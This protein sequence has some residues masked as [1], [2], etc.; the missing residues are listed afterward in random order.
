MD[1]LTD[2]QFREV[3]E[4]IEDYMKASRKL[5]MTILEMEPTEIPQDVMMAT[6][7]LALADYKVTSTGDAI[8]EKMEEGSDYDLNL[9]DIQSKTIKQKMEQARHG[10]VPNQ[11]QDKDQ[12]EDK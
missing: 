5:M 2:D 3:R 10:P 12:K 8:R 11:N 1:P 4:A 7:G 9:E 6:L